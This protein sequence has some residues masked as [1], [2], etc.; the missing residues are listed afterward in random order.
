M[1]SHLSLADI[2]TLLADNAVDNG[3]MVQAVD[4][5]ATSGVHKRVLQSTEQNPVQL[6]HIM[7]ICPLRKH[8]N[9]KRLNS[10]TKRC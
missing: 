1:S 8:E 6:L 3:P 10:E 9:R 5:C 7:L 4:K 2:S